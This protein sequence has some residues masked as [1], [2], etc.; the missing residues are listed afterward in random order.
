MTVS[1]GAEHF[2][3]NKYHHT[4]FIHHTAIIGED[5][6]LGESN[7]IGPYCIINSNCDIGNNNR[8]ESHCVVNS[9]PEHK[10]SFLLGTSFGT[11]IGNG[12]TIREF[13]TINAGTKQYTTI[14]D[15]N[16]MLRG[17]Y[18]GHDSTVE[19]NVTLSCNALIGGHSYIME[20]AN[21]GL[22]AV[23]HQYSIIGAYS[24]IGM[25]STV[26]KNSNILPG[27]K[28]A[29]NPVRKLSLNRIGLDRS[30]IDSKQYEELARRYDQ[31]CQR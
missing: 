29:G 26:V 16:I 20:G 25:N 6:I 12:N 15:N 9:L 28:Y 14:G 11:R 31:L 10:D 1:I 27:F 30:E 8:F 21:M 3:K 17:S 18:V 23:C 19:N 24:I 13:T 7:Y 4:N 5:V 2:G 22:G